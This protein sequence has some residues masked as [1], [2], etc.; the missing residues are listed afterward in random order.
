M[1]TRP[2]RELMTMQDSLRNHIPRSLPYPGVQILFP[3]NQML[4]KA[5][6]R[7]TY[8]QQKQTTN[9]VELKPEFW[10]QIKEDSHI[11]QKHAENRISDHLFSS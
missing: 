9:L 2:S 4:H 8:R 10:N 11:G 3:D 5:R 6:R 7:V 1:R